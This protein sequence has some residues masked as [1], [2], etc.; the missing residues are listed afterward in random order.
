MVGGL[1][2]PWKLGSWKRIPPYCTVCH[3]SLAR[4]SLYYLQR[5]LKSIPYMTSGCFTFASKVDHRRENQTSLARYLCMHNIHHHHHHHHHHRHD[6]AAWSRTPR[7]DKRLISTPRKYRGR[8]AGAWRLAR[9]RI[10]IMTSRSW[11]SSVP[12]TRSSTT[13]AEITMAIFH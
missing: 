3:P 2:S 9:S 7:V 4:S 1:P 10:D 5:P 11:P 12:D 6:A 13:L 8:S